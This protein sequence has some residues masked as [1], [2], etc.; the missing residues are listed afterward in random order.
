MVDLKKVFYRDLLY[1]PVASL[2]AG[3]VKRHLNFLKEFQYVER[4]ELERLQNK[5]KII[6]FDHAREIGRAHV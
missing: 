6:L 1:Y 5:R 2:Q 3:S 4:S